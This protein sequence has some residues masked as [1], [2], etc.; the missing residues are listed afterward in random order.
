MLPVNLETRLAVLVD[1]D[2]VAAKHADAIFVRVESLGQAHIRR[3]YGNLADS[4][5]KDW[6]PAITSHAITSRQQSPLSPLKNGSDIALAIDAMDL[7]HANRADGFCIVSSDCDFTPLA[8]R[9]REAGKIVYGFGR[10]TAQG[11]FKASCTAYFPLEGEPRPK[12]LP[13]D[14]KKPKL[15]LTPDDLRRIAETVDTHR[16]AEGWTHLDLLGLEL[17]KLNPK[18]EAKQ[19]GHATLSKLLDHIGGFEMEGAATAGA[20]TRRK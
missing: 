19:Y 13:S 14:P 10:P 3:L 11:S 1:G 16:D 18:I 8:I 15:T 12:L 7:L 20:R 17:R 9:L 2:N 5:T 6:L 4:T